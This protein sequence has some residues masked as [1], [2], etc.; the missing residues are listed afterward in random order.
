[1][2]IGAKVRRQTD[3]AA[4]IVL[5]LDVVL[6][7]AFGALSD[8]TFLVVD[9]LQALA[10][11]SSQIVLLAIAVALILGL[12][13]IDIALGAMLVAGSVASGKA[14]AQL[15]PESASTTVLVGL[16]I[17]ILTGLVCMAVSAWVVLK[18]RVN[19]FISSLAMLGIITGAVYVATDG[20]NVIGVP[21]SVQE[22]FG[23]NSVL[24]AVPMPALVVALI[25]VA[26]W[27]LVNRTRLGVHILASGS[28]RDAAVRAGI[29]TGRVILVTFLIAGAIVG[30]A[31]FID[32]SRF[33]TT[34]IA[35]HQT[36][37]LSAIAGAVIGG[38]RLTGGRVSILGAVSGAL[39]ASILQT[40]LVVLG[41][42]AFY[43]LIAIGVVLIIAVAVGQWR[44]SRAT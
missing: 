40:G 7:L 23:A 1:V 13:E 24:D 43:Q 42:P 32:L 39:L 30:V 5:A 15:D 34:D 19:S 35:G 37:A 16:A 38:T 33:G 3:V 25:A 14:L 17:S 36:D 2:K 18:L 6:V 26:A 29:R 22:S 8:G 20:A 4:W 21:I 31:G 28:A 12:G 44:D 11:N 27:F 41:L 10:V 9:N